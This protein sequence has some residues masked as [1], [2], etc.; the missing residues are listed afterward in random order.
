MIVRGDEYF[1]N[2]V[3]ITFLFSSA[4]TTNGIPCNTIFPFDHLVQTLIA[5]LV[6]KSSLYDCKQVL[7][8]LFS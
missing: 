2:K 5:Q 4:Q 3:N 6:V 8:V 7:Y 1:D